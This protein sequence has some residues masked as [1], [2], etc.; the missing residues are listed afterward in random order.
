[1]SEA[2]EVED[3][4][5]SIS[6]LTPLRREKMLLPLALPL[7]RFPTRQ[8]RRFGGKEHAEEG[9]ERGWSCPWD[10]IPPEADRLR[11]R[12]FQTRERMRSGRR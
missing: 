6:L 9:P 10:W 12:I 3:I 7:R 4:E 5:R 8:R 1:M 2:S 11:A